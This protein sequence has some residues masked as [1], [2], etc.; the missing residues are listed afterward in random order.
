MTEITWVLDPAT[1]ETLLEGVERKDA[2]CL[3]GDL[4]P[5]PQELFCAVPVT[6]LHLPAASAD[7]IERDVCVRIAGYYHN[8][9]IEG[10]GRRSSVLFQG[11]QLHCVGCA[12]ENTWAADGGY[13]IPV[14]RLA[15]ALLDPAFERDGISIL[16][17]EPMFQPDGLLALVRALRCQGC[18]HLLVYSGYTYERLWRL[19]QMQPA[20]GAVLG[21]VD[22]LI[23]GPFITA[24]ADRGGPWTGSR[25]QR[26]I[27]LAATRHAG[28]LVVATPGPRVRSRA[29][30]S[31][32]SRLRHQHLAEAGGIRSSPAG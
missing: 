2:E 26:V 29:P 21:E 24:L 6:P 30:T 31:A 7:E 4:L 18:P 28:R 22:V 9:L 20:I 19:A 15:D 1:G 5:P 13:L 32:S 3:V 16:G 12:A 27:D 25:N 11:C 8:S 14:D 10:P 17:G 23:D